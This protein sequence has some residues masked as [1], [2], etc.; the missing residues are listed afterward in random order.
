MDL[1]ATNEIELF[2]LSLI[3]K[4]EL[5]WNFFVAMNKKLQ[6]WSEDQL[7]Q[8]VNDLSEFGVLKKVTSS[9][10]SDIS[11][12]LTGMGQQYLRNMYEKIDEH[13]PDPSRAI[14]YFYM[15]CC[16]AGTDTEIFCEV[17]ERSDANPLDFICSEYQPSSQ[18]QPQKDRWKKKDLTQIRKDLIDNIAY[19]THQQNFDLTEEKKLRVTHLVDRWLKQFSPQATVYE[20]D[21]FCNM[22]TCEFCFAIFDQNLFGFVGF[23]DED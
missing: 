15:D 19:G 20:P 2:I 3:E 18:F 5:S 17:I 9:I 12:D 21:Y 10:D 4:Y 8:S 1:N 22:G 14:M 23:G 13:W 6:L 11:Y 16:N 7:R